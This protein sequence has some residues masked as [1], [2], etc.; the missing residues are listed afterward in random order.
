MD[1][2][3]KITLTTGRVRTVKVQARDELFRIVQMRGNLFVCSKAHGNCCC[4]WTEK[5]RA[6]VNL[7]LYQAEWE[8]RRLRNKVHLSFTGCL[9]PCSVGNNVLLQL[10]G[11]SVWFKDLNDDKYIPLMFDYIEALLE[12]LAAP[13]PLELAGHI[14][15]RYLPPEETGQLTAHIPVTA[16]AEAGQN[17]QDESWKPLDPVCLMEVDPATA[18]W[19]A[20]YEGRQFY[21]CAPACKKTFEREPQAYL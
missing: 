20:E 12:N 14:F 16:E 10:S 4:G 3:N 5:G 6:P 7:D 1:R 13:P 18:R 15:E 21:F 17:D 2:P 11:R 9:G 8:R 19:K